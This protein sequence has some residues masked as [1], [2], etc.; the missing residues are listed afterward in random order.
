MIPFF[1]KNLELEYKSLN[2]SKISIIRIAL[3]RL[4]LLFKQNGFIWICRH[5]LAYKIDFAAVPDSQI[6]SPITLSIEND[7]R[8]IWTSRIA[9]LKG[10]D[11]YSLDHS[12][13]YDFARNPKKFSC[14]VWD[15][16]SNLSSIEQVENIQ[17][18]GGQEFALSSFGLT[19]ELV[20]KS[21]SRASIFNSRIVVNEREIVPTDVHN[22]VDGSWPTDLAFLHK[23]KYFLFRGSRI[24]ELFPGK[25][26]FFGSSTSWFHF[27]IEI[28]PRFLHFD[29]SELTTRIPVVER[30][31]PAQI[32][33][34]IKLL[35]S[36]EPLFLEGGHIAEFEDIVVCIESRFPSGLELHNR[37]NDI[38]LVRDFFLSRLSPDLE[39][40][41]K[42]I[43]V[44][45]SQYLLRKSDSVR[46]LSKF[47]AK[48]GF[49]VVDTGD[50]TLDEQVQLFASAEVV[51]GEVGSSLTNL[52][53]CNSGTLVIELNLHNF[54]KGFFKDFCEVLGHDHREIDGLK[55]VKGVPYALMGN[56]YMPFESLINSGK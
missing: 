7:D 39:L 44:I 49:I 52:L 25:Y 28:L 40:S 24:Q 45:R 22:F 19:P 38:K 42:K 21:F 30:D 53:F 16:H 43:F 36:H 17:V 11:A 3:E 9:I 15:Y 50:L 56:S 10:I 35:C 34:V 20:F 46:D 54:M 27:L 6:G 4:H 5:S 47:C 55:F 12:Q 1:I 32:L 37:E 2:P 29:S 23:G 8:P 51:I 18:T 48:L 31:M 26:L 41:R 33:Q 13:E 14:F